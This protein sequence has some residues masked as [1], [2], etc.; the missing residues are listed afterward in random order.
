MPVPDFSPGEV[1]T[2]AAMDDIGLWKIKSQT[3]GSAVSSQAV[4]SVF[5]STYDHYFV[6]VV[7]GAGSTNVELRIQLGA[8][9]TNYKY[10]LL[11]GSFANSALAEGS[12][13][14]ANVPY[15]GYAT[16]NGSSALV[17]ISNPNRAMRTTVDAP[18]FG[19]GGTNAGNVT[20]LIDNTTQYTDF[21]L[22][23]AGG[24]MTGGTITVYGWKP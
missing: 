17:R 2:A 14:A 11:Y 9:T 6:T 16:T 7:G 21:T 1:L 15:C 24:T 18:Y 22:V 19:P 12:T 13:T 4:T 23:I 8:T 3:I 20:G 10:Q 5:S